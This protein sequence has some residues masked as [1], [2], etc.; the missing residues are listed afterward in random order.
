[1]GRL[2]AIIQTADEYPGVIMVAEWETN[3]LSIF[4]EHR[5]L[6]KLWAA[7]NAKPYADAFLFTYCPCESFF[8]VIRR[9]V[10]YWQGKE[11][12][13]ETPP[14]LYMTI[15]AH[16]RVKRTNEFL[17]VR[18]MEIRKSVVQLWHDLGFIS[19]PD[20]LECIGSI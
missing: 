2:D 16:R 17:F 10:E 9:V 1:M 19:A 20:Y 15:V 18:T 11:S 8:D 12:L 4:G 3:A 14:S 5:E 7:A 6:D 13:R